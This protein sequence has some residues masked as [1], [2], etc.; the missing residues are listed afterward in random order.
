MVKSLLVTNNLDSNGLPGGIIPT[1]E[2]LSKRSFSKRVHDFITISKV[3]MVDNQVISPF[4]VIS[5][6]ICRV[7]CSCGLLP[8]TCTIIVEGWIIEHLFLLIP[9]KGLGFRTFQEN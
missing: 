3:I 7:I 8:A 9:G 4:I 5:I 2:H 1:I 6:I